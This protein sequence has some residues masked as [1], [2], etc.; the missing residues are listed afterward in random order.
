MG[1]AEYRRIGI[2]VDRDDFLALCHSRLVLDR[3][4][5]PDCDCA[6]GLVAE[7]SPQAL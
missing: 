7:E 6:C 1:A 5:D 3:A 4:A 2:V